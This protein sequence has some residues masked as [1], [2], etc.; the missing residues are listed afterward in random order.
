MPIGAA[1]TI[2]SSRWTGAARHD[3]ATPPPPEQ[4][5]RSSG[6]ERATPPPVPGDLVPD[7][8]GILLALCVGRRPRS[9]SRPRFVREVALVRAH[10]EPI[11]DAPLLAASYGRE[12]FQSLPASPREVAQAT[13]VRVAYAMRW[14]ELATGLRLPPLPAWLDADAPAG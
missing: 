7:A 10:L 12:A 9:W 13:P 11:G 1:A 5:L 2:D 3:P 8:S 4:L 14:A 6:G